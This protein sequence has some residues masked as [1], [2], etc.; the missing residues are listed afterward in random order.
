MNDDRLFLELLRYRNRANP[1][2]ILD[3]LL[4]TPVARQHDG[5][6]VV[7]SHEFVMQ[8]LVDPRLSND[9]RK[10]PDPAFRS[11]PPS[12]GFV[13]L[14]PPEHDRLRERTWEHF[15]PPACPHL[16]EGF[17]ARIEELVEE[18]LQAL[19][20]ERFDLVADFSYPIPVQIICDLLGVPQEDEPKFGAW[21]Q[22]IALQPEFAPDFAEPERIETR[23][24]AYAELTA[25]FAAL[26]ER[27]K[28]E[29]GEGLLADLARA[30]AGGCMNDAELGA[31]AEIMLIGGHETTVNL[32]TNT[33][34]FLLRNP[35]QLD[36]LR[37]EPDLVDTTVEEA[38]RL[39]P[40]LQFRP[41]F[42]VDDVEYG[43]VRIPKGSTVILLLAAANRDPA[44]FPD[45]ARFDIGR[46]PNPHVSFAGGIHYC[47]GA[48]LG[49]LEAQIMVRAIATRLTGLRLLADP[50][51]YRPM[52]DLRGPSELILSAETLEGSPRR[53]LQET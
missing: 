34:L 35:D 38:L 37:A 9:P 53:K 12:L 40:P 16:V 7:S 4:S 42:T 18:R 10:G 47:F 48:P 20:L 1:E 26:I 23:D 25:Y 17:R 13:T 15:G 28:R 46:D 44:R 52:A 21:S 22:V 29:G 5:I 51:P 8:A 3:K 45:A 41:R 30:R 50:P 39:S 36:R 6:Y 43:G 27:L 49:R 19:D 11:G 33:I 14:D 32:V 2:P 24:R 31:T